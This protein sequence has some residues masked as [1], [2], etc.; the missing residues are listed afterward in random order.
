MKRILI[1]G[2]TEGFGGVE[3]F[4]CNIKKN[5]SQDIKIDFLVHQNVN[6][7]L[8][9]IIY[10]NHSNVYKVT[11]IKMNFIKYIRD[12]FKFYKN[13][14]YDV[15]HLNECDA[16]MFLYCLPI[17]FDKKTKLIVHSHST[18]ASN[19]IIHKII[20]F[21]QN[22][23]ANVKWA[24]SSSA[25]K[26]MYG[27]NDNEIIIHNGIELEKYRY[28]KKIREK[29][30]KELGLK[31]ELVFCSI[32]RFTNEKNHEKIVDVFYEYSKINNNSK[33]VLV[34]IGPL[35]ER[36]KEK[37]KK[38]GINEK[39]MFLN[40]RSDV[41]ELY[42]A[43][44]I[45]LLPSLYEGLPFVSLE[46]QT[47]GIKFFASDKVSED[48]AITDL[49]TFINLEKNSKEWAQII[50]TKIKDRYNR[51]DEKY[52]QMISAAGYDIKKVCSIIEKEYRK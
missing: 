6:E 25:Y 11:G 44:D 23:R 10:S 26:Y 17:L 32:A 37:V 35:Q 30:R 7:K 14:K 21:F 46:G 13:H 43:F 12:I 2:I 1:V 5:I 4:I 28:D 3:T 41:N 27:R 29:K 18:S 15:I 50:A 16:K 33:L 52:P 49:V 47:N 20:C 36:I 51:S 22:R 34:G 48:I 39:V 38:L 45:F 31:D 42:S 9:D 24:C 8:H 19:A 40:S